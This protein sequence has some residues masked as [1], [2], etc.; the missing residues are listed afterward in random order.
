KGHN[1]DWIRL[2]IQNRFTEIYDNLFE[3][4]EPFCERN[5]IIYEGMDFSPSQ[6]PEKEKS[7]GTAIESFGLGHFG[8]LGTVFAVGFLTSVLHGIN[9]PKIGFSG[10]MQPLLEDYTIAKRN[11]EGKVSLTQLLLNSTVCGLGLDCIPLP[12]EVSKETLTLLMMEVAT[13]STRLK[14]PLTA[15]LMPISGKKIGDKTE[16]DFEYFTNSKICGIKPS[17]LESLQKFI[18]KNPGFLL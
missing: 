7:I 18:K 1:L 13:I 4:L 3:I 12:G 6:Y 2:S 16:F 5:N 10:F 8:E 15:R 11:D 17:S 14:K 9:R